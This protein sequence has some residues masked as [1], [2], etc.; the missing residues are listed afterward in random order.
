LHQR[1]PGAERLDA[2]LALDRGVEGAGGTGEDGHHT[3]TH[4][5]D[6]PPAAPFDRSPN[7]PVVLTEKEVELIVSVVHP[8][9]R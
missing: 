2:H 1:R 6:D 5:L 3:I 9:G 8:L 7:D 4:V